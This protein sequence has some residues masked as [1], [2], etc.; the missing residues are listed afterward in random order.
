MVPIP[1]ELRHVAMTFECPLCN[2]AIIKKGSWFKTIGTFKCDACGNRIRLGYEDKLALF[3][4]TKHQ[5][6]HG[7]QRGHS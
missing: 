2:H 1:D 7:A 5:D 4:N 6:Q 3:E